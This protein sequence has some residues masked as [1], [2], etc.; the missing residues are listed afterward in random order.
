MIPNPTMLLLLL[1]LTL[2]GLILLLLAPTIFEIRKPENKG[3]RKITE[4]TTRKPDEHGSQQAQSSRQSL[5]LSRQN[6][7]KNLRDVLIELEGKEV[8]AIGVDA[9]RIIGDVKLPS[10]IEVQKS[11]V[12]E[13]FFTIGERCLFG[14]SVKASKD[15]TVGNEVIVKGDLVTDGNAYIGADVMIEGSV[16]AQGSVKL[17]KDTFVGGSVVAGGDVEL[18]QNARVAKNI[19]SNGEILVRTSP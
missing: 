16:H 3:P 2:L 18:H 8:S 12:V 15:I 14:G 6:L 7:P 19:L 17:G 4:S 9:V 1:I 5:T 13:G 10:N 11:I